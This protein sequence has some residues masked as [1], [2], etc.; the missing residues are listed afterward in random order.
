VAPCDE[1]GLLL[2]THLLYAGCPCRPAVVRDGPLDD[3]IFSHMEPTHPGADQ[4][5][6][7]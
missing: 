6:A 7:S 4:V 1:T 2:P 3:P 5:L